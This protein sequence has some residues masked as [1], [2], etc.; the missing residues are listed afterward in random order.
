MYVAIVVPYNASFH[1]QICCYNDIIYQPYDVIESTSMNGSSSSWLAPKI[2]NYLIDSAIE[3][4]STTEKLQ[5]DGNYY[6]KRSTQRG[7]FKAN[8]SLS[9]ASTMTQSSRPSR[10]ASTEIFSATVSS[11]YRICVSLLWS[12]MCNI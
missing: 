6:E 1:G 7:Q 11:I 10:E 3:R 2:K 8:I 12:Y 9:N 4:T 5:N